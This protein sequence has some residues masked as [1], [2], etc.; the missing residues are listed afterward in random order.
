MTRD[1]NPRETKGE[2]V[3]DQEK[4]GYV[5]GEKNRQGSTTNFGVKQSKLAR[6]H[7]L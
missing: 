4:A 7:T 2:R 1:S 6:G 5:H 3:L